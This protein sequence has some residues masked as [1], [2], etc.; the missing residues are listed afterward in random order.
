MKEPFD[1]IRT[2]RLTEKSTVL[3]DKGNRHAADGREKLMSNIKSDLA[4][5]KSLAAGA[6][7][8]ETPAQQDTYM[9]AV[10]GLISGNPVPRFG[11]QTLQQL[12]ADQFRTQILQNVAP[13]RRNQLEQLWA[14]TTGKGA[15]FT[16]PVKQIVEAMEESGIAPK[17]DDKKSGIIRAQPSTWTPEQKYMYELVVEKSLKIV[18]EEVNSSPTHQVPKPAE[19]KRRLAGVLTRGIIEGKKL[20]GL[21]GIF[22][23]GERPATFL[24]AEREGLTEKWIIEPKP[25][26]YNRATPIL[27]EGKAETDGPDGVWNVQ[28]F[29]RAELGLPFE[30][31]RKKK[32]KPAPEPLPEPKLPAEPPLRYTNPEVGF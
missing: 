5:L 21:G 28:Q 22:E 23:I 29:L 9:D 14:S 13:H 10:A 15:T 31:F 25:D 20:F 6:G 16:L 19:I 4:W 24:E 7:E 18:E 30:P 12:P 11:N 3:T 1:I 26:D 32:P 2:I 17:K 8:Q 27:E